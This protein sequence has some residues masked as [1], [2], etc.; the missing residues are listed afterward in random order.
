M[1]NRFIATCLILVGSLFSATFAYADN[2]IEQD[3]RQQVQKIAEMNQ[4]EQRCAEGVEGAC[5]SYNQL[6]TEV[7]DNSMKLSPGFI[8]KF[9][10]KFAETVKKWLPPIQKAAT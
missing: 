9:S 7:K 2:S 3:V 6:A 8:D 1:I 5:E 4:A 10:G